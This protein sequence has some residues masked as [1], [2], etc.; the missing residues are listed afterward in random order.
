MAK[1]TSLLFIVPVRDLDRA[2]KFYNDAFELEVGFRNEGIAFVGIPG[3]ET[4]MGLLLDPEHAGEG[5]QNV[6]LHVDHALNRDD[7]LRDV[8]AAGGKIVERGEHA[9]DVP[10]ARIAD[11][12]GNVL[13]I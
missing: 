2:I 11:V 3:T 1:V 8:E 13:E 4:S 6:G 12:D 7:V 5:P 9:P 10:F